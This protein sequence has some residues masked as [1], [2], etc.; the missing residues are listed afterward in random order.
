[1]AQQTH[2]KI[3]VAVGSTNPVKIRA[4]RK[5]F[6]RAFRGVQVTTADVSSGVRDQPRTRLEALSGARN[7]A[8][9]AK[10]KARSDF[11]VGIEAFVS[12]VSSHYFTQACC[13][14]VGPDGSEGISFSTA[15]ELP[16]VVAQKVKRGGE[17]GPVMDRVIGRKDTKKKLGIVGYLTK[18]ALPRYTVYANAVVVA[19]ARYISPEIYNRKHNL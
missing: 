10:R 17:V 15:I 19:L 18:G 12:H 11:G 2:Q 7:R 6:S 5:G 16:D 1:M 3:T 14:V 13:V 4:V 9:A 8:V